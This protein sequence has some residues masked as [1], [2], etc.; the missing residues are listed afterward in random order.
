MSKT[1]GNIKGTFEGDIFESRSALSMANI[2]RPLQAGISGTEKE[3]ADSI[4]L[5][6]GYEDDED[7]G[8]IIIYTGHGGRSNESKFQVADQTLTKG[9]KALAI[10]CE[11][12]LPIRVSRGAS[13]NSSFAPNSGYRYDG[14][15]LITEYWREKGRSGFNVWRFRLEK[16]INE[17]YSQEARPIQIIKEPESNY[18]N[19]SRKEYVI[20]KIIRETKT[21]QFIKQLYNDTCQI[22]GTQIKSPV[23]TYSEAA[24]IKS[25]GK[26]HNGPDTKENIICLCPNHHKMFDLGIISIDDNFNILGLENEKLT[27][28]PKHKIDLDLIKYHREHHYKK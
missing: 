22:C 4:V 24:H 14:L 6:G 15:F 13:K 17:K 12:K 28:N 21:A 2:H 23:S 16:I 9:N 26:P 18:T 7:N 11:R 27:I 20:K 1:F 10:S 5:S 3:G 19:T 25:L 8:D